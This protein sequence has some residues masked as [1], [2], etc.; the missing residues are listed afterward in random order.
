MD[1]FTSSDE[2]AENIRL[3]RE[4]HRKKSQ[5]GMFQDYVHDNKP[6]KKG[7]SKI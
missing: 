5:K 3:L 4:M 6:F 2:D 1:S 7:M